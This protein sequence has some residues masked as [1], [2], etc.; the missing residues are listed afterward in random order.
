MSRTAIFIDGAYLEK[1]SLNE[2]GKPTID[3]QKLAAHIVGSGELLRTS[4]SRTVAQSHLCAYS[5]QN[6]MLNPRPYTKQPVVLV[7]VPVPLTPS[8][9]ARTLLP[10]HVPVPVALSIAD[11][12]GPSNCESQAG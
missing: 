11:C 2:F 9:H 5:R 4:N 8:D 1:L 12:E 6:S 7:D 10:Y 3:F